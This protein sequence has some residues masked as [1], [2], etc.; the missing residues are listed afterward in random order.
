MINFFKNLADLKNDLNLNRNTGTFAWFLHRVTGLLL[1]FYIFMHLV[2]LGSEFWKG[3]GSFN[4]L[5]GRFEQPL[6]KFLEFGLIGVIS[7][8]LINGLRII[9]SDFLLL[10]RAH[11]KIFWIGAV[12]FIAVMIITSIIFF[13]P[14][15]K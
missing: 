3:P 5:M 2:V 10:T 8:H 9:L 12:I 13:C 15:C 1:T 6:F 7:F 11:K 4:D 14:Y